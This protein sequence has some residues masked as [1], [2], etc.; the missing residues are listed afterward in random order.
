MDGRFSFWLATQSGSDALVACK[1]RRQIP[2]FDFR[3]RLR[4]LEPLSA[5][6]AKDIRRLLDGQIAVAVRVG[7]DGDFDTVRRPAQ[8]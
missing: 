3:L 6:I 1:K 8:P 4:P 5:V 7:A 2:L